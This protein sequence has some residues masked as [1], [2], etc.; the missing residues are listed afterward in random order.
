MIEPTYLFTTDGRELAPFREEL[1]SGIK[2]L[3]GDNAVSGTV[4]MFREL[5]H[6]DDCLFDAYPFLSFDKIVEVEIDA[7]IDDA[8]WRRIKKED[9]EIQQEA[10]SE[11][12]KGLFDE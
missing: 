10:E 9:D 6:S 4:V 5:F 11:F 3:E 2:R 7:G 8:A 1:K 12:A